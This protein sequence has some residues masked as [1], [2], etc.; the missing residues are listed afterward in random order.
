MVKAADACKARDSMDVN[1]VSHLHLDA[2]SVS[3]ERS[4]I[5][6]EVLSTIISTKEHFLHSLL[7]LEMNVTEIRTSRRESSLTIAI[8]VLCPLFRLFAQNTLARLYTESRPLQ[9][10]LSSPTF[11]FKADL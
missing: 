1:G 6:M 11:A 7:E 3:K 10:F 9:L 4:Q 2:P 5:S 8:S